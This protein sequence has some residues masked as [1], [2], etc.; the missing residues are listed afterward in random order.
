MLQYVLGV[1]P[2]ASTEVL[3]ARRGSKGGASEGPASVASVATRESTVPPSTRRLAVGA[4][5]G[6]LESGVESGATSVC[7]PPAINRAPTVWNY[8]ERVQTCGEEGRTQNRSSVMA[9]AHPTRTGRKKKRPIHRLVRALGANAWAAA[10]GCQPVQQRP[11]FG[12]FGR[13]VGPVC[14]HTRHEYTRW[15]PKVTP[16]ACTSIPPRPAP[17]TPLSIVST[18]NMA[19]VFL[20]SVQC[21]SAAA[22]DRLCGSTT[23][24]RQRTSAPR[25]KH[26]PSSQGRIPE[27]ASMRSMIQPCQP[28]MHGQ[29]A[30]DATR[31]LPTQ[32]DACQLPACQHSKTQL[33][34]ARSAQYIII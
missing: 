15:T 21:N 6:G 22:G 26:Q 25:A 8:S 13:Q 17:P 24:P 18:C 23:S 28:C 5:V 1:V 3:P 32:P 12:A 20:N 29:H 10:A 9:W 31:P 30:G 4:C 7:P 2:V 11:G 34:A 27:Q 14:G 16:L 19:V 33:A